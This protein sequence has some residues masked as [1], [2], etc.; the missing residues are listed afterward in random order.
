MPGYRVLEKPVDE[1]HVVPME[2]DPAGDLVP[3]KRSAVHD[4]LQTKILHR[5]ARSAWACR[6]RADVAKPA[7]EDAICLAE[8]V[9]HADV[10]PICRA[11]ESVTLDLI[12]GQLSAEAP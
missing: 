7:M 11:A 2:L 12:D 5:R 8:P 3:R 4:E 6:R 10:G 9:G 1:V